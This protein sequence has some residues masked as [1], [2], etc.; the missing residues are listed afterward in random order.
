MK[1]VFRGIRKDAPKEYIEKGITNGPDKPD[2]EGIIFEDGT[3]ALRWLTKSHSLSFFPSFEMFYDIHGHPE[4]GTVIEWLL[5][6]GV[7][8]Y[9]N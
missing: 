4:Y 6:W 8:Q 1:K 7:W 5:D 3:V 9:G 2:Y